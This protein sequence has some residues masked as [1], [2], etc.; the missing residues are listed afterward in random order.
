MVQVRVKFYGIVQGVFFRANTKRKAREMG[1]NGYVRNMPDGSVEAV[2]EGDE[3][4]V[5]EIIDWCSTKI[6]M[7]RVT[8][9]DVKYENIKEFNDFEIRY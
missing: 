8:K 7:A 9:V 3:K 5:K 6:R 4:K 2:F 1:I